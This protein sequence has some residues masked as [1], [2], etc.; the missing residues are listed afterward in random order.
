MDDDK[1]IRDA[2]ISA[3]EMEKILLKKVKNKKVNYIFKFGTGALSS[4]LAGFIDSILK[5]SHPEQKLRLVDDM[6]H[7]TKMVLIS[8]EKI[9]QG[10]SSEPH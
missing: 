9:R 1:L 6:C 7:M 8:K 10:T 4:L 3:S 5:D 2:A